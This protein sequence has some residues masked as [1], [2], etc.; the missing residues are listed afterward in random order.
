MTNQSSPEYSSL[1]ILQIYIVLATVS[2]CR[3]TMGI[4]HDVLVCYVCVITFVPEIIWRVHLVSL[5]ESWW[6]LLL[7]LL[8]L[9]FFNSG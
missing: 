7:L 9:F 4:L 1:L 3:G 8:L 2:K 5:C 6:F